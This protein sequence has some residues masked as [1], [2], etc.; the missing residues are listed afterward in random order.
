MSD[1]VKD[2]AMTNRVLIVYLSPSLFF[3]L[4]SLTLQNFSNIS[5]CR[6]SLEM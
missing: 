1:D 5:M 4:V 6:P 2:V 3:L